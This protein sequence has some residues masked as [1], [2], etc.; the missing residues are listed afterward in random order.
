METLNFDIKAIENLK[1]Y[2]D[3][4]ILVLDEFN[5]ISN[6][7]NEAYTNKSIKKMIHLL[8]RQ[9]VIHG[10]IVYLTNNI[11]NSSNPY[12]PLSVSVLDST[13]HNIRQC[14]KEYD[15]LIKL[16][17]NETK[18]ENNNIL[19]NNINNINTTNNTLLNNNV[20]FNNKINPSPNVDIY[21]P[22][23]ILFFGNWCIHCRNFMPIWDKFAELYSL[24]NLNIIKTDNTDVC[25]TFG[26]TRFPTIR[27]YTQKG[28]SLDFEEERTVNNLINFVNVNIK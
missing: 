5:K 1:P 2:S 15:I 9:K 17:Q 13:C 21:L 25:K 24:D 20:L 27:F 26:I 10:L 14:I 18:E 11:L 8:N 28:I 16:L 22:T 6:K 19:I 12:P 4:L 7:C 3:E 23:I